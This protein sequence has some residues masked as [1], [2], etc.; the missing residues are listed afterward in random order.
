VPG[1]LANVTYWSVRTNNYIQS[2]NYGTIVQNEAL[3]PQ[4]ITRA[5]ACAGGAPC[6][7]TS[8]NN[9]YLNFGGINV[10]GI[11]YDA[12]YTFAS[13]LGEWT[14]SLSL[15]QTF[16]YAVALT[17]KA[18]SLSAL[19]IAQDSGNWAP[20]WKGTL[21]L[22]WKQ[23]PYG[24]S[25]G[26]RYVGSYQDYDSPRRIGNF[27]LFDTNVRADIGQI[28]GSDEPVVSGSYLSVGIVNL[29]DQS[30][31]Y[32]NFASGTLG[33]DPGQADI[34]GRYFYI[35]VGAKI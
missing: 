3:F 22:G 29:F 31:Q 1:L 11:D 5:S 9:T 6:P 14:P 34:R 19:G 15:T 25:L 13:E 27:W 24:A 20:R 35:Q 21:G 23:G 26:A 18:P 2:V 12:H 33:Y 10:S 4:Y 17:P 7:I 28:T 16:Q 32:S 8:I 30:P